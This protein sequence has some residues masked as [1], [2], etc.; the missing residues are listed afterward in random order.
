MHLAR[1]PAGAERL[2]DRSVRLLAGERALVRTVARGEVDHYSIDFHD[3]G[4]EP[5]IAQLTAT[6]SVADPG[7]F[8]Q[9]RYH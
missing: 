7:W 2:E 8:R 5:A 3:Q 9:C 6:I 4:H 1:L